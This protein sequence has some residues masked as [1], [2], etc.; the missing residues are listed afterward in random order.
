[1]CLHGSQRIQDIRLSGTVF[2]LIN[3]PSEF[4]FQMDVN[5]LRSG[6]RWFDNALSTLSGTTV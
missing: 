2:T 3:S 6:F 4:Q 1:M 5:V